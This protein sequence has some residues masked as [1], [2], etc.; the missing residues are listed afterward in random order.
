MPEEKKMVGADASSEAT[1]DELR[2]YLSSSIF[3]Q[4][5]PKSAKKI[6]STF[7]VR[8]IQVIE[9]SSHELHKVEG[10][11]RRRVASIIE[12]WRTP[13]RLKRECMILLREKGGEK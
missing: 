1:L 8:T 11:G 3:V 12:G 2:K 6:V 10:I 13:H 9:K 4:V 7:G 5:G